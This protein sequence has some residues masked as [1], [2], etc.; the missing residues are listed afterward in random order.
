MDDL[1]IFPGMEERRGL[2]EEKRGSVKTVGKFASSHP[3]KSTTIHPPP[4]ILPLIATH[5]HSLPQMSL[6]PL[7]IPMLTKERH[8]SD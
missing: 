6:F 7:R 1:L 8:P 2:E 4:G 3:L 5:I